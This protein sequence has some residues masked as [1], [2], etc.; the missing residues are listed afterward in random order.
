MRFIARCTSTEVDVSA[1]VPFLGK[2]DPSRTS[3]FCYVVAQSVMFHN[4]Q[5]NRSSS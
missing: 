1:G 3:A 4:R 2:P 5:V